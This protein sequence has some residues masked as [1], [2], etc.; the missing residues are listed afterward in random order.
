MTFNRKITY[1]IKLELSWIYIIIY[2]KYKIDT[3]QY[4]LQ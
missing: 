2:N 1:N 3:F 4:N